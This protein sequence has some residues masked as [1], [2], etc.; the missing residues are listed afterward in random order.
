M[1]YT[2]GPDI[3]RLL[4]TEVSNFRGM[5]QVS[6]PGLPI[7]R[8]DALRQHSTDLQIIVVREL[9]HVGSQLAVVRLH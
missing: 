4:L 2:R 3:G 1:R 6:A 5:P 8:D 9:G 7:Q